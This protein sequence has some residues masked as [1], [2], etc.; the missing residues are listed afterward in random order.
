MLHAALHTV[1]FVHGEIHSDWFNGIEIL[2]GRWQRGEKVGYCYPSGLE[3][4]TLCKW[5]I[6]CPAGHERVNIILPY[7]PRL[8]RFSIKFSHLKILC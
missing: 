6:I 4:K 3:E 1:S 7:A 8:S 2:Q 5:D